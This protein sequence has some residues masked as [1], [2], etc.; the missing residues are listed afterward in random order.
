MKIAIL[1]NG[2]LPLKAINAIFRKFPNAYL[3]ILNSSLDVLEKS[4]EKLLE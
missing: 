4:H 2:A 3:Y 1:I